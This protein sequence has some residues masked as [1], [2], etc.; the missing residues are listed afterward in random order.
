MLLKSITTIYNKSLTLH[1]QDL[2]GNFPYCLLNNSYDFISEDLVLD[3][4]IIP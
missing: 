3:Q 2:I 1:T 4:L